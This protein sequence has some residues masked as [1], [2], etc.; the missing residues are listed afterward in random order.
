MEDRYSN[1]LNVEQGIQ[2][3]GV[4]DGHAGSHTAQMLSEHLYHIIADNQDFLDKKY[5]SALNKGFIN[6]DQR[7]A[8]DSRVQ[9]DISGSTGVVVMLDDTEDS[10]SRQPRYLK[11]QN[12]QNPQT[13]QH[14]Q[15]S[16][17][18]QA[19]INI[20]SNPNSRSAKT[21]VAPNNSSHNFTHPNQVPVSMNESYGIQP[22]NYQN[23]S[24]ANFNNNNNNN[25]NP[26]SSSTKLY[27]AWLGD[28]RAVISH[29]GKA[30]NLTF[31][32]LPTNPEEYLRIKRANMFVSNDRVN[33]SLAIGGV[34][35]YRS[36]FSFFCCR[37][38]QKS[39]KI[40]VLIEKPL[41]HVP[42]FWRLHFQTTRILCTTKSSSFMPT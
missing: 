28:S 40:H 18:N 33:G 10:S 9:I 26:V 20:N 17:V 30:Q 34:F 23:Q 11:Q 4:F 29:N 35:R 41:I 24:N 19:N 16:S 15:N 8:A 12:L 2:F 32:H 39:K 36:L 21:T 13:Q 7:L 3:Y 38:L 27:V 42:S 31:D 1:Y 37:A 14:L 22:S 6:M 25:V 5:H